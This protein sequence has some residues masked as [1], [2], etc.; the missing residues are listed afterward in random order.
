MRWAGHVARTGTVRNAHKILVEKLMRVRH[1]R[2]CVVR[3][4]V[5]TLRGRAVDSAG[6]GC[7]SM[8]VYASTVMT[9]EFHK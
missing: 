4:E 7:D 3:R 9:F 1:L 5:N 8:T 6:S 2:L